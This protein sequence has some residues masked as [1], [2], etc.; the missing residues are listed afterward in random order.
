MPAAHVV[1]LRQLGARSAPLDNRRDRDI[2]FPMNMTTQASAWCEGKFFKGEG[3]AT[4]A[5]VNNRWFSVNGIRPMVTE[6]RWEVTDKNKIEQ[7]E[8][9]C[10]ISS[11]NEE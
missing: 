10:G 3:Y 7:L 2:V 4:Y 9:F 8:E 1:A 6:T 5:R 11:E